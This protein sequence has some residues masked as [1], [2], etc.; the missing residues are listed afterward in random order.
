MHMQ[1]DAY[2]F[3]IHSP[4]Y[5]GK[6]RNK[7]LLYVMENILLVWL[8]IEILRYVELFIFFIE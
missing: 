8:R 6:L 5:T 7:A 2:L 1:W 4:T 3:Y